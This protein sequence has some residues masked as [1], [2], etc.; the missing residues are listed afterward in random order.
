MPSVRSEARLDYYE[1]LGLDPSQRSLKPEHLKAAYKRSLLTH[2]PDKQRS[3]RSGHSAPSIDTIALAYKILS[4][5]SLKSVYDQSLAE[6]NSA[7]PGSDKVFHTGLDTVDLDD[8]DL[9]EA[10]GVWTRSCRCGDDKGF[11]VTEAEL[12]RN[13]EDGELITGCRGCSL[14]LRVLFGVGDA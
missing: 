4:T 1:V 11:Q 10:S 13:V 8:L 9:D 2:H 7:Q 6:Q 3:E 14:W 5:P 12:E